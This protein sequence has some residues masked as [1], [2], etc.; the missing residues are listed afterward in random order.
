MKKVILITGI[1]S[2]FGKHTA[3]LL[4]RRGHTVYGTVRTVPAHKILV[5]YLTAD[6]ADAATLKRAVAEVLLA[7]GRIDVLV[8]NAG[9]HTG[10]PAETLQPEHA[11]LQIETGFLGPATLMREVL[12]A[13]RRQGGGT[14]INISSIG[15]LVGL[16]FQA[17]YSAAKFAVEGFSE[18]LRMETERF[19]IRTVVVNPGDFRTGNTASRKN[20]L[21]PTGPG[22]PYKQ[23]YEAAMQVIESDETGGWHPSK[24]AATVA[25]IAELKNPRQRYIVG[26]FDQKLAVWLRHALPPRLFSAILKRHYGI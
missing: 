21:A 20:C 7:E 5:K 6:L 18:A 4:A 12:P 9:M 3:E 14:I 15:G 22:D 10:G 8:N 24:L 13:M 16:P 17:F 1:S 23:P 19:N 26:A 11:R 25:L 2:G